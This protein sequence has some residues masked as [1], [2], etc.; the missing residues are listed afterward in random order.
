M[1]STLKTILIIAVFAI[2]TILLFKPSDDK[3]NS[4]NYL[5]SEHYTA[6]FDPK[7]VDPLVHPYSKNIVY[8]PDSQ[9][10]YKS[11][12]PNNQIYDHLDSLNNNN[13][14]EVEIEDPIMKYSDDVDDMSSTIE[15]ED[16][17]E[18]KSMNKKVRFSQENQ[19]INETSVS[20]SYND[21]D[22]TPDYSNDS[23][24]IINYCSATFKENLDSGDIFTD[25]IENNVQ[26][27]DDMD[28]DEKTYFDMINSKPNIKTY[29]KVNDSF[30]TYTSE[31]NQN[32]DINSLKE[33]TKYMDQQRNKTM[34]TINKSFVRL[35]PKSLYAI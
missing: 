11:D 2:I 17:E 27:N 25:A 10:E 26:G 28:M 8:R 14:N 32:T 16:E 15:L 5:Q 18:E 34:E 33:I 19:V 3:C 22:I 24:N 31:E 35:N 30:G 29:I 20:S 9:S 13:N 12:M 23:N 4:S 7:F 1:D 21:T 6:S